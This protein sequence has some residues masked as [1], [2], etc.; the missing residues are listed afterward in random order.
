MISI[1]VCSIDPELLSTLKKNIA[2][3]VG[4]P[5]EVIATDNRKTGKGICQVY[6]EAAAKA[7]YDILCFL[8]EDISIQTSNWGGVL[9]ELFKDPTLGLV[10]VAGSSYRPLTPAA[11]GGLGAG[12]DY[13]HIV[14]SD[15]HD[16]LRSKYIL[17][18]RRNEKLARVVCLDGVWLCTTRSVFSKIQFDERTFKGFHFYDID[19]SL[20][21]AQHFKVEVTYDILIHHFSQGT[22]GKAWAEESLKYFEKWHKQ[23]PIQIEPFDHKFIVKGEKVAF[24]SYTD[25]LVEFGLP[26]K[27][28]L[29]VLNKGNRF[30]NFSPKLFIKL[31]SYVLTKYIRLQ[32]HTAKV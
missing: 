10:G 14:Q 8:H 28:A 20:S 27:D 19:F 29:T 30:F 9:A 13:H 7:R 2:A 18:N 32:K 15:K 5:F 22:Y 24:R 21:V 17:I 26:L 25:T 23:L 3:T 16:R 12:T 6:N 11:W 31:V 1:I 4:T